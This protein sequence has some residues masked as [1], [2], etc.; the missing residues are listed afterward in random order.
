MG[1]LVD[2]LENTKPLEYVFN[3]KEGKEKGYFYAQRL[4][5]KKKKCICGLHLV[6]LQPAP[7]ESN[8]FCF[9]LRLWGP[10]GPRGGANEEKVQKSTQIKG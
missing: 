9:A 2:C 1:L 8:A 5:K 6:L 4:A 10:P 3:R 7:A